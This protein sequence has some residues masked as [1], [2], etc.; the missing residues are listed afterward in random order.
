V[1][2]Q[3]KAKK[4]KKTAKTKKAKK[5]AKTEKAKKTAKTKKAK[6]TAK[7]EKAKK[8]AKTK[9]AKK[10]KKVKKTQRAAKKARK[11]P[12]VRSVSVG[13]LVRL[14]PDAYRA[15]QGYA[16]TSGAEARSAEAVVGVVCSVRNIS[17]GN[18]VTQ[19]RGD[20]T[21][22]VLELIHAQTFRP[23]YGS[24]QNTGGPRGPEDI[25]E[26]PVLNRLRRTLNE[27]ARK[28]HRINTAGEGLGEE[29]LKSLLD[30]WRVVKVKA[31]V[32]ESA[33]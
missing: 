14:P 28:G 29:P 12:V 2:P 16:S 1:P 26:N 23:H 9:K 22:Y 30:G 33:E 13:D 31:E 18:L 32:V 6:K 11:R 8:T 20:L 21:G 10:T 4:A 19:T 27:L 5:T 25:R 7:T 15:L 24:D 17:T 3:K